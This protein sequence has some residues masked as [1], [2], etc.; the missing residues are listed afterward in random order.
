M[1]SSTKVLIALSITIAISLL[2]FAFGLSFPKFP[3]RLTGDAGSYLEIAKQFTDWSSVLSYAGDRTV[4]FP[5]LEFLIKKIAFLFTSSYNE[6]AWI[7]AIGLTLLVTHIATAWFFSQWARNIKLIQ[8][9]NAMLLLFVFFA[10]YPALIGHTTAPLSDT[11][12]TDLVVCAIV[13]MQAALASNTGGKVF[14][15]AGLSAFFWGFAILVRPG[16]MWAVAAALAAGIA[17]SLLIA[18]GKAAVIFAISLGCILLLSPFSYNCTQKYGS[19]CL[20]SPGTFDSVKSA[21]S[22]LRGARTIWEMTSLAPGQW[23]PTLPDDTMF[24]N[25]FQRCQLKTIV[26]IDDS[27][28]TGCLLTRPL[29]LPAYM[30]KKWIG[31]LDNFRFTPY[32]EKETPFG[33][34]WLSRAYAS[35]AWIGLAM[36]F[37]MLFQ[38]TKT[39]YR[40]EIKEKLLV[41]ITPALLVVY[42]V[43]MLAQHT[44]LHV[45]DRYGFPLIPL[46]AVVLAVYA[47]KF[48]HNYRTFGYRKIMPLALYCIAAWAIF[49]AQIIIWDNVALAILWDNSKFN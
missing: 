37:V 24:T 6:L 48:I 32:L 9:E 11:L 38:A 8:S 28:L 29:A 44:V 35:L 43:V 33:L 26:G 42:S 18:R 5:F 27:S 36:F 45:E 46:C 7:N 4:G 31:L 22:G 3:Y 15:R 39:T 19:L 10:T 41:P 17:L 16:N 47:E 34:R 23:A 40:S 30:V 1:Q 13:S 20:Q 2:L 14:M 49:I 25:Y 21:Q 12:A